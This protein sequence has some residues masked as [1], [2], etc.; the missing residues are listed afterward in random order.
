[1]SDESEII[2]EAVSVRG[3]KLVV[4]IWYPR[5]DD[6][7]IKKIEVGLVDVRAADSIQIEYDFDRDGWVIKQAST[8]EWSGD[9]PICNPDWQEVAFVQA[10]GR[11]KA[12]TSPPTDRP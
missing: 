6:R 9:D 4:D 3:D 1:M 5:V 8:F 11:E 7:S 10:W 12:A 2:K